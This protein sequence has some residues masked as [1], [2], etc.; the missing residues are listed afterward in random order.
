MKYEPKFKKRMRGSKYSLWVLLPSNE[1][2]NIG[3]ED[4]FHLTDEVEGHLIHAFELGMKATRQLLE[5]D[6]PWVSF[7]TRFTPEEEDNGR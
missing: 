6:V 5:L 3:D 1:W 4:P 7:N 2:W